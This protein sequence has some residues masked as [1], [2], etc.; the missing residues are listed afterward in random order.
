MRKMKDAKKLHL[1]LTK[2]EW[3][4][5]KPLTTPIKIQN[6]LDTFP[7]NMEKT[8]E[9]YMSPRQV[10]KKKKMHC[11]EGALVAATALWINGEEPLILDLKAPGDEDHVITL[12]K[13]NGY[14]GAISKTNHAVLRFRDPVYRTLRELVLSYFNEY[15]DDNTCRKSLRSFSKPFNLKKM[16]VNW[17]TETNDLDHI[18]Q[19]LDD[20]PHQSIFPKINARFIRPAD[21]MEKI[22]CQMTEWKKKDKGT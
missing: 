17:I 19:K 9:T 5:F 8:G 12:Y 1:G 13:R 20:Y 11:F 16:G 10:I 21:H 15:T 18:V 3:A 22:L 14:W 2:E 6:F 4:I 7:R